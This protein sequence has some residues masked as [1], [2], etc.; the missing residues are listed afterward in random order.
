MG[1]IG[2][3]SLNP[4]NSIGYFKKYLRLAL[5]TTSIYNIWLLEQEMQRLPAYTIF[6]ASMNV[7]LNSFN[8]LAWLFNLLLHA[9]LGG[10]PPSKSN[11]TFYT[12]I[13]TSRLK[14]LSNWVPKWAREVEVKKS[15]QIVLQFILSLHINFSQITLDSWKKKVKNS[16]VRLKSL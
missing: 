13:I 12:L 6:I 2:A 4:R 11:C 15:K 3:L 8:L 16:W 9:W 7:T 5:Y 10:A 1:W 14:Q